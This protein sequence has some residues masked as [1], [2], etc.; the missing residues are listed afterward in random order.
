MILSDNPDIVP[1]FKMQIFCN[2]FVLGRVTPRQP[3]AFILNN[4]SG[5]RIIQ[6]MQK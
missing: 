5:S 3:T 6:K 4:F 1:K 2:F